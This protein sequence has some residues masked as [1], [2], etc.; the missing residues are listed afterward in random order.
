[1][2]RMHLAIDLVFITVL[3]L[4]LYRTRHGR[5]D[6]VIALIGAN[7]GVMVVAAVL[8]ALPIVALAVVDS[9]RFMS[10]TRRQRI[11]LD[12]VI[13]NEDGLH[14]FLAELLGAKS[15]RASVLSTDL[16]QDKM[17]VDV[18]YKVGAAPGGLPAPDGRADST[19]GG[20]APGD[21]T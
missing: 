21:K 13:T 11:V 10:T 8:M 7:V 18:V 12:R 20:R 19:T 9:N 16:I 1:M 17:V 5:K 2:D 15:V 14:D 3:A 6:L 4:G